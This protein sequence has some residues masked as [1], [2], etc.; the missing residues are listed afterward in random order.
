M[1]KKIIIAAASTAM[2][3]VGCAPAN[4]KKE[5]VSA[6]VTETTSVE[7]VSGEQNLLTVGIP[8]GWKVESTGYGAPLGRDYVDLKK[9]EAEISIWATLTQN[10]YDGKVEDIKFSEEIKD[11]KIGQYTYTGGITDGTYMYLSAEGFPSDLFDGYGNL[12]MIYENPD[13]VSLD[14]GTI[15]QLLEQVN[16]KDSFGTLTVVGDEAEL[17][18]NPTDL[19]S[20]RVVGKAT[21]G[22][23]YNVRA[24]IVFEN[25]VWYQVDATENDEDTDL[26]WFEDTENVEFESIGKEVKTFKM[27]VS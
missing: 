12:E 26:L 21:K 18:S 2:M 25:K 1:N 20:S 11:L 6:S 3:L 8:E 10:N 5:N 23:K 9:G 15:E 4:T 14:D 24:T 22:N 17:I 19:A 7:T 13:G 16:V 27:G